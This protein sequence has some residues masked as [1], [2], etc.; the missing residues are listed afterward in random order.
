VT[1]ITW[2]DARAFCRWISKMELRSYRLPTEAEWE[3]ACRAG[4]TTAWSFGDEPRY[5][6]EY[7]RAY[8]PSKLIFIPLG[9]LPVGKKKANDFGLFVSFQSSCIFLSA[10]A[11]CRSSGC[12]SDCSAWQQRRRVQVRLSPRRMTSTTAGGFGWVGR[13]FSGCW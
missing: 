12:R 13:P 1:A 9:P 8:Q 10:A 5:A 11:G 7:M 3:H 6:S 2:N 4:T